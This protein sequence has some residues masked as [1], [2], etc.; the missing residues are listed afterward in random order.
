MSR[1]GRSGPAISLFAF[2]DIITSVTAIVTVITL[3]LALDLVQRK[4]GKA[5][6][7]YQNLAEELS[8][9]I[10]AGEAELANLRAAAD[11]AD[12]LVQD[13]AATSPA[14]LREEIA[15]REQEI[16]RLQ[17]KVDAQLEDQKSLKNDLKRA[18]VEQF[19]LSPVR[20]QAEQARREAEESDRKR[21]EV[22]A[23]N[24]TVFSLPKGFQKEGWLAVID[25]KAITVA[26]LGRAAR[27][28]TF[29]SSGALLF[30]KSAA[31]EFLA[32]IERERL[33]SAHFL[34]LV[35][36]EASTTFD[37]VRNRFKTK[38][39]S[40]G[41]DLIGADETLIHPERGAGQ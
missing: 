30:S 4:Q 8:Q 41:F 13:V 15:A 23:E 33:T 40:F 20:E 5:A 25:A 7:S 31:D 1:R 37:E 2:Q 16:V 36:P 12:T 9:R 26:P 28:T 29:T 27:P 14:Q 35:R 11:S 17:A 34:L 3:L 24:R 6:D 18:Q 32:W 22:K 21:A 10:T 38:E 19:D 39:V